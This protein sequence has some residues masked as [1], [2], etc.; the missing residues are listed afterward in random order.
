VPGQKLKRL[1]DLLSAV[2]KNNAEIKIGTTQYQMLDVRVKLML[3][4]K[5]ILRI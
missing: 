5:I 4:P 3:L 2:K 1:A